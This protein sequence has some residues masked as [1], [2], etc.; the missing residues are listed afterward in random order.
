VVPEV[1]VLFK[2][3]TVGFSETSELQPYMAWYISADYGKTT[4]KQ[5]IE[6]GWKVQSVVP[7]NSNAAKQFYITFTK[8][9]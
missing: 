8:G 3:D 2:G 6:D 5:M 4:M 7:Y 9:M 1:K